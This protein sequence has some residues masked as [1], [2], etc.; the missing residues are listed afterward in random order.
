MI[1]FFKFKLFISLVNYFTT[2]DFTIC[3][4]SQ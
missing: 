3:S 1:D 2:K 4:S